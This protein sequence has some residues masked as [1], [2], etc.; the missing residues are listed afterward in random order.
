MIQFGAGLEQDPALL[1]MYTLEVRHEPAEVRSRKRGEQAVTRG[2]VGRI[3][4]MAEQEGR[5]ASNAIV[6]GILLAAYVSH[7]RLYTETL[8]H[9]SYFSAGT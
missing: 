8:C 1:Q 4:K 5:R 6:P 3:P 9:K 7:S 2:G